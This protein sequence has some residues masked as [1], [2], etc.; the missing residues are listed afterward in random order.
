MRHIDTELSTI[1]LEDFMKA[2]WQKFKQ[3]YFSFLPPSTSILG[4]TQNKSRFLHEL[5]TGQLHTYP[6]IKTKH[7]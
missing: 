6:Y 4:V 7:D 5:C 1:E 2:L 3:I